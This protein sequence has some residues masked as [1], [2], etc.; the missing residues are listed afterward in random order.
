[1]NT[2]NYE[3]RRAHLF[4]LLDSLFGKPL[5]DDEFIFHD[6]VLG[7]LEGHMVE[8]GQLT[9]EQIVEIHEAWGAAQAA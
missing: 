9:W 2:Y 1:M 3:D 7:E 5:T 4:N 6:Q 8:D